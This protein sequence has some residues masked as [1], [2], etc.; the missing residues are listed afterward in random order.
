MVR[1]NSQGVG[2]SQQQQQGGS[3]AAAAAGGG[4]SGNG[5]SMNG[6]GRSSS[7][8]GA[9]GGQN[10][11]T[12]G[13]KAGPSNATTTTTIAEI[14]PIGK[15]LVRLQIDMTIEMKILIYYVKAF[16]FKIFRCNLR[17][18]KYKQWTSPS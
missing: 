1:Y 6:H 14:S 2:A 9:S 11:S 7:K 12:N 10:S 5:D 3:N 8:N 15:L 17:C 13:S 18:R 4:G 16:L